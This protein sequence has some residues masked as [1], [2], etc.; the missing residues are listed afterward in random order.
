MEKWGE[1]LRE[2]Q[3]ACDTLIH[4][5]GAD[6]DGADVNPQTLINVLSGVGDGGRVVPV[7]GGSAVLVA[8]YSHGWSHEAYSG[9]EREDIEVA[10]HRN[11]STRPRL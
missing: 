5:G 3:E 6:Y 4:D 11:P 1:L 2:T 7:G 9:K 10:H 8:L